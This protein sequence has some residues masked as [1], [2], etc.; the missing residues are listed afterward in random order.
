MT[1]GITGDFP[2]RELWNAFVAGHPDGHFFQSWE[3]GELQDGLGG[4]PHRMAALTETGIAGVAQLLV[5]E[6]GRTFGYVPRGPVAAA[7]DEI[8][9]GALIDAATDVSAGSGADLLRL[10]PQWP[11]DEETAGLLQRRGFGVARQHI[12]PPRTLLVDLRPTAADLW[13]AFESTT[14]NRIRVAEKRGVEVSVAREDE[15]SEFVRLSDETNARHGLRL[16]RADMFVLAMRL[17]GA[18]DTMRLFFARH[19]GAVLAGIMVFLW[20]STATYLWGASASSE[21]AR[22]L[23]PN[24]LLHWTAMQWARERGCETYDLFGIPD[25]DV[26]VLEAEYG[27]QSGGWWNLY[28][29][30]RGFGG[31]VHRH[32]GTFDRV[33]R[34][35]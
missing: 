26:D 22:K 8:V 1:V 3:W 34:R 30:K 20:G 12:M 6:G 25:Y 27:K 28:R 10:E 35:A 7:R 24:Q 23:N 4:R 5:F 32:L 9:V 18:R 19:D 16:G 17:F 11:S 2:D 31:R 14:R 13:D 15:I 33:I 29:F 21:A